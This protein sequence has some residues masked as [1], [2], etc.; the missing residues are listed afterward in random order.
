MS[1]YSGY[2]KATV[3]LNPNNATIIEYTQQTYYIRSGKTTYFVFF[4]S[5]L[6]DE[7]TDETL[8]GLKM[9]LPGSYQYEPYSVFSIS[10]GVLRLS[11]QQEKWKLLRHASEEDA[12]QVAEGSISFSKG[13]KMAAM[14]EVRKTGDSEHFVSRKFK[15]PQSEHSLVLESSDSSVVLPRQNAI[16]VCFYGMRDS[17]PPTKGITLSFQIPEALKARIGYQL[18]LTFFD[19]RNFKDPGDEYAVTPKITKVI[20]IENESRLHFTD[21]NEIVVLDNTVVL[22]SPTYASSSGY[23]PHLTRSPSRESAP[24]TMAPSSSSYASTSESTSD[25]YIPPTRPI[26]EHFV[27]ARTDTEASPF[28]IQKNRSLVLKSIPTTLNSAYV[29]FEMDT[30]SVESA[31]DVLS[32][33]MVWMKNEDVVDVI[34]NTSPISVQINPPSIVF[35]NGRKELP[36]ENTIYSSFVWDRSTTQSTRDSWIRVPLSDLSKNSQLLSFTVVEKKEERN[37]NTI[38]I[39]YLI[40]SFLKFPVL[41]CIPY[42]INTQTFKFSFPFELSSPVVWSNYSKTPYFSFML[43]YIQDGPPLTII[44][45]TKNLDK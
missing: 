45:R 10:D 33:P 32:T 20:T 12:V 24:M 2:T 37:T 21:I 34:S 44:A 7:V 13:E 8:S 35:P 25:V 17:T 43:P 22:S 3:A 36:L 9:T 15:W 5:F 4:P 30:L 38:S 40:R 42:N 26:Y 19:R 28:L 16:V 1:H 41:V 11:S 39:T 23:I 14:T 31:K 18:D 29:A 6:K 27:S